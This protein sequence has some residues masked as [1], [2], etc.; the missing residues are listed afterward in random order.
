MDWSFNDNFT[1]SFVLAYADPGA[2]VQQ[3]SGRTDSFLYGMVFAAY[4]Y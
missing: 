2:A 1:V 4:K 3:S